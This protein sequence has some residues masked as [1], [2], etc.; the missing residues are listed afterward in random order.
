MR[1]LCCGVLL[2]VEIAKFVEIVNIVYCAMTAFVVKYSM[3]FYF[4]VSV[5]DIFAR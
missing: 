2:G 3:D 4:L 1:L 5:V